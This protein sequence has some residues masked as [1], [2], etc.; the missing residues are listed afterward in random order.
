M[1]ILTT[2]V[3]TNCYNVYI[4]LQNSKDESQQGRGGQPGL[5]KRQNEHQQE[6]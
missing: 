2:F 4:Y 5:L 3:C 1:D 6:I